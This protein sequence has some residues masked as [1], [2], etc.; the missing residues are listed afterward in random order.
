MSDDAEQLH[1]FSRLDFLDADGFGFVNNTAAQVAG[2]IEHA[3]H[4]SPVRGLKD[5]DAWKIERLEL[6]SLLKFAEPR[7]YVLD[8]LPRMDQLNGSDVPT[9][10]LDAFELEALPKLRAESD[11]VI[12]KTSPDVR[13]LGSLRATKQCLDCHHVD[14]GELL[15]AFS[16]VLHGH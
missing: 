5:R 16:Y 13:M 8:H 7:V 14:R 4:R 3:F 10:P 12:S 1:K 11:V 9:R 15:G 2:F 6:V